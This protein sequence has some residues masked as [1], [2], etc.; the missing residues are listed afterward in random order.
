[1]NIYK[2]VVGK[3]NSQCYSVLERHAKNESSFAKNAANS[4]HLL[5]VKKLF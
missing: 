1:M 3:K 4:L 5:T 2:N